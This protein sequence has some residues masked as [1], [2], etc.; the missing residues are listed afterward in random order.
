MDEHQGLTDHPIQK[1][2]LFQAG[3]F[4]DKGATPN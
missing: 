2:R 1:P 3:L 4:V